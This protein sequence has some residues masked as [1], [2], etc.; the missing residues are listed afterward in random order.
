MYWYL[1]KKTGE[2]RI[3]GSL[4]V[5]CREIDISRQKLTYNFS[6]KK[7]DHYEDE[8]FR[9]CRLSLETGG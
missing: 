4:S 1:N 3:F 8:D 5:L 6:Q 9:I 2:P 7:L